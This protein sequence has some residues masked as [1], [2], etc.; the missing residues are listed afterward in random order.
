M[1]SPHIYSEGA[2]D[3][4]R[5][6][7]DTFDT[8]QLKV[9]RLAHVSHVK[10]HIEF[11][12]VHHRIPALN[13]LD[14]AHLAIL[15]L[16]ANV[17]ISNPPFPILM[18][19]ELPAEPREK[20]DSPVAH[21]IL[22]IDLVKM[23]MSAYKVKRNGVTYRVRRKQ[24]EGDDWVVQSMAYL[25]VHSMQYS[26]PQNLQSKVSDTAT[27]FTFKLGFI[28][29][30][31]QNT[32][33]ALDPPVPFSVHDPLTTNVVE[34]LIQATNESLLQGLLDQLQFSPRLLLL[35]ARINA[36][37]PEGGKP[38]LKDVAAHRSYLDID[39]V[40][41]RKALTRLVCA[42]HPF[43]VEWH[44]RTQLARPQRKW[45][46]CR[47]CRNKSH[48]EDEAH[49]LIACE[50]HRTLTDLR[51]SFFFAAMQ[52]WPALVRVRRE[53]RRDI[54]ILRRV[55][56]HTPLQTAFAKFVAEAFELSRENL[57]TSTEGRNVT[58]RKS[59][60]MKTTLFA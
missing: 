28:T 49:V 59:G 51:E 14:G 56:A 47:F 22:G 13:D 54:D 27:L 55:L 60:R 11:A 30:L 5:A 39:N 4:P 17:N 9:Q 3:V 8:I 40:T 23:V 15:A 46:I 25:L 12:L 32:L 38:P 52:T 45:R 35:N 18:L 10:Q 53:S 50:G 26:P 31:L 36:S 7:P 21:A 34:H 19:N 2:Y 58:D 1:C 6:A 37:S 16:S 33:L 24:L 48:I 57:M 43:A 42:D 29:Y 41:H 20:C 44:R